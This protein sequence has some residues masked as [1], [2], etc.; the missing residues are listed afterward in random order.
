MCT[1]GADDLAPNEDGEAGLRR[2]PSTRPGETTTEEEVWGLCRPRS[3]FLCATAK[4]VEA[5]MDDSAAEEELVARRWMQTE[6]TTSGEDDVC[7]GGACTEVGICGLVARGLLEMIS[8]GSSC[9]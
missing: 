6:E 8:F 4:E 2:D 3:C 7:S 1:S 9:P 5:S